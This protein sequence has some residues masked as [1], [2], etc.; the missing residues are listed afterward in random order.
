MLMILIIPST[1][2]AGWGRG[3]LMDRRENRSVWLMLVAIAFLGLLG[4]LGLFSKPLSTGI[5]VLV[6]TPLIQAASFTLVEGCFRLLVHRVPMA[7]SLVQKD[8]RVANG[9]RPW[10]DTVFWMIVYIVLISEGVVLCETFG[11]ELPSRYYA[12]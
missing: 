2:F 3:W 1:V 12:R 10:R 5:A 9:R 11:V 4:R 7:L 8:N 6:A